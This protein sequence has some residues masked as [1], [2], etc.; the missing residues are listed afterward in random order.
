MTWLTLLVTL[1]F[2]THHPPKHCCRQS[3]PPPGKAIVWWQCQWDLGSSDQCL[4]LCVILLKASTGVHCHQGMPLPWGGGA[5]L[6]LAWCLGGWYVSKS[7]DS[8]FHSRTLRCKEMI[9]VI[10]TPVTGFDV[11]ADVWLWIVYTSNNNY[12]IGFYWHFFGLFNVTPV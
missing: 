10:T 6:G 8:L 9:N 1:L 3:T 11:V 7:K 12:G 5:V 2:G 4:G